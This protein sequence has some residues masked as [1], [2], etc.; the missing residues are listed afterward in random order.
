MGIVI[1][2]GACSEE[3]RRR[4]AEGKDKAKFC[5]ESKHWSRLNGA[6]AG[7]ASGAL[8][9]FVWQAT[10]PE[11]KRVRDLVSFRIPSGLQWQR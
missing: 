9:W 1:A 4:I 8:L 2:E 6:L 3:K 10:E 7:M 5:R 11:P